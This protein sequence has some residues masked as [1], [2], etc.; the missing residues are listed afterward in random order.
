[1]LPSRESVVRPHLSTKVSVESNGLHT[2]PH[3]IPL[4]II[5]ATLQAK[6]VPNFPEK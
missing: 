5:S 6:L 1:M 3:M 2:L 4:Y